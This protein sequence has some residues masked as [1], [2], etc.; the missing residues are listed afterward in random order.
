MRSGAR[1]LRP[2]GV[3][4]ILDET[5]ELYKSSFILLVG[6]AAVMYVPYSVFTQYSATRII[7]IASLP[8]RAPGPEIYSSLAITAISYLYLFITAP[9]VTG[10]LTYAIS[11][12]Y[13]GHK[14]TILDS[15]RR[16]FSF[17]IFGQLLAAIG[18]KV[19]VFIIPLMFAVSVV[20]LSVMSFVTLQSSWPVI[21]G[22]VLIPLFSVAL[23]IFLLLRLALIEPAIIVETSGVGHAISR[24]WKLMSGNLGKCLGLYFITLIVVSF[25]SY[26]ATIPTQSAVAGAIIKGVAPSGVFIALHTIISALVGAALAPV[27]SIVIILLYY[28]IRIRKEGFDLELLADEMSSTRDSY[29]MKPELPQEQPP[30]SDPPGT[31]Q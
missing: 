5:V 21:L 19:I 23:S 8:N 26:F 24:S 15:F 30:I 12:V 2:M 27:T 3:A 9:L 28:D 20:F 7:S 29:W 18:L 4:D 1:R 13:L 14:P 17:S 31:D 10:A 11:E 22:L 16:V 25:V 6:I